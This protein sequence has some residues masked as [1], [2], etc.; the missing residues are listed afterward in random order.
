VR[1][2]INGDRP[3]LGVYKK[4]MSGSL[5]EGGGPAEVSEATWHWAVL[6][7]LGAI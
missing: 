3:G 5:G 2:T 1:G 4:E 6:C 7:H